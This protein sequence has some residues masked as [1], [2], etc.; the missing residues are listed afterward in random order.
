MITSHFFLART[1]L[2]S[3][4]SVWSDLADVCVE[5]NKV[6]RQEVMIRNFRWQIQSFLL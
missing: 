5:S 6:S 4:F 2:S 1:P 3:C